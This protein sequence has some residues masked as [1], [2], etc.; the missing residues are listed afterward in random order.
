MFFNAKLERE[1]TFKQTFGDES[2]QH[3]SDDKGDRI[4][5]F[6]TSNNLVNSTMF[7]H[8]HKYT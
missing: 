8:I 4:V 6:A 2:V 3:N 1:D 7:L 5:N